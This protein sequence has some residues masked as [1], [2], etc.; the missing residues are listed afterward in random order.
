MVMMKMSKRK[1]RFR[2]IIEILVLLLYMVIGFIMVLPHFTSPK[3]DQAPSVL[4]ENLVEARYYQK[5]RGGMVQCGLCFRRCLIPDGGRGYCGVRENRGGTLYTLVYGKPSAIH[6]D[7]IEKEPLHHFLPGS[8][9]LCIGTAGC[10]FKCSFCHNWQLSSRLPE[11]ILRYDFPPE[12]IVQVALQNNVK[13]ISF[14]YNEPTIFYEYMYDVAKLA[15]EM[16]LRVIFHTNGAMNPEPLRELL[17]YVDAVTVDLKAFT[18]EFYKETSLSKLEPVLNT[19]KVIKEEGVW[20]EIVNLI[21]P[22]LNDNMSDIREM[23]I[24]I[25][26][27]LG[28]DVPMHFTRFFPAYKLTMLP[29]TP[30]ETLEEARRICLEVGMK[31]VTIGNVPGHEANSLYCPGCKERLIHRAHFTVIKNKIEDGRCPFCGYE[32]PGVWE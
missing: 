6:I 2:V 4:D 3:L 11:E 1:L 24:W 10:N 14:T 13:T 26:E 19:L 8:K 23:C 28:E 12:L 21:I 22:T 15:K 30:I 29:P 7:P 27:N 9:I 32:I 25:R 20:L 31:Y 16:G 17:K 5:Q 18:A